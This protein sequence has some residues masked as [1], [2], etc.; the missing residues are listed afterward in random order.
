MALIMQMSPAGRGVAH[1]GDSVVQHT[2]VW[3]GA[4][5]L[6]PLYSACERLHFV[7]HLQ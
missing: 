2:G 1:P 4:P 3:G 6:K 5:L 7:N